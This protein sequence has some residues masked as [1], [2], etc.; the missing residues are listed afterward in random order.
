MLK[1]Y[2]LIVV[3]NTII[4]SLFS[5]GL[6]VSLYDN[7]PDGVHRTFLP[8]AWDRHVRANKTLHIVTACMYVHHLFEYNMRLRYFA[9]RL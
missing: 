2:K 3:F 6:F 7:C 4:L 1:L 5:G 8:V 9:R